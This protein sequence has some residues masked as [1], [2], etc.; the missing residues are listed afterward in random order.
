MT[1]KISKKVFGDPYK[2]EARKTTIIDPYRALF[3]GSLPTE[4]Q[5]WTLCGPM[6]TQPTIPLYTETL[7][8]LSEIGQMVS[9]GLIVP[10]QFHGVEI[11]L[12]THQENLRVLTTSP[13]YSAHLYHGELTHVL[14]EHLPT[15]LPS[16][17][18]V[19]TN[20]EPVK[21]IELLSGTLT[22]LNAVC[23]ATMVVWNFI[24]G[25]RHPRVLRYSWSDVQAL[26]ASNGLL[27]YSLRGWE[28]LKNVFEYGGTGRSTT[29]MG[30]V[31]FYRR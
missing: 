21:A 19:D 8:A 10:D 22:V 17:V 18:Y 9:M 12:R 16:I 11:E 5:Y 3:G 26:A 23:A 30:T 31:V 29:T 1:S 25:R 24:I 7:N 13:Y 14:D 15:L 6:G 20:T 27:Q 28:Q 4:G 2:A